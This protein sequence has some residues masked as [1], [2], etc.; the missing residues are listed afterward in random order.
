MLFHLIECKTGQNKIGLFPW[1][2]IRAFRNRDNIK[3]SHLFHYLQ[4]N[5]IFFITGLSTQAIEQFL[6]IF[7]FFTSPCCAVCTYLYLSL[8]CVTLTGSNFNTL[9]LTV[10][11]RPSTAAHLHFWLPCTGSQV[12]TW[13][14]EKKPAIKLARLGANLHKKV[15]LFCFQTFKQSPVSNSHWIDEH[16]LFDPIDEDGNRDKAPV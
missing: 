6:V 8:L 13:S 2:I 10:C 5:T 14:K 15:L 12:C 3:L 1:W 9:R 4:A 11:T 16:R 7:L